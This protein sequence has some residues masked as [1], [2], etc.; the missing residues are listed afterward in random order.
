[1]SVKIPMPMPVL[2]LLAGLSIQGCTPFILGRDIE[3]TDL[4]PIK[5]GAARTDI[6][7]VLGTPKVTCAAPSRETEVV[8]YLYDR[9]ARGADFGVMFVLAYMIQGGWALEPIMTPLALSTRNEDVK[10]QLGR[11]RIIYGP[12]DTVV[13]VQELRSATGDIEKLEANFCQIWLNQ[14]MPIE[15]LRQLSWEELLAQAESGELELKELRAQA[16]HG[17]PEAQYML[18]NTLRLKGELAEARKWW[19]LAANQSHGKAQERIGD[20]YRYGRV[21][22]GEPDYVRAYMWYDLAASNGNIQAFP[23]KVNAAGKMTPEQIAE[24][25]RL[26][27]EWQPGSCEPEIGA[28]TSAN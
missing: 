24:A 16:E 6:E 28:T 4:S 9:G 1:M 19:C 13:G 3:P 22:E 27:T 2:L 11:I 10:K 21:T 15:E 23:N 7:R 26:A 25:E 20:E 14:E 5:P 17:D 8:T 18:G 12:D